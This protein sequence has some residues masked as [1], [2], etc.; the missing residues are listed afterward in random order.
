MV[1]TYQYN[2]GVAIYY[3][4]NSAKKY[5]EIAQFQLSN[6]RIDKENSDKVEILI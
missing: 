1:Y 6:L 2:G 5:K 4:N 3:E